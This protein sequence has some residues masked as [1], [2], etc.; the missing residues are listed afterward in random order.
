MA[1]GWSVAE[2][3]NGRVSRDSSIPPSAL[4]H[5]PMLSIDKVDEPGK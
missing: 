2:V 1:D 5:A 3:D 4:T